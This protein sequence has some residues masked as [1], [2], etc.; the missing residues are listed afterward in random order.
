M[1][2]LTDDL[3]TGII[4]IDSQH[5]QLFNLINTI[6]TLTPSQLSSKEET[7][8]I[9]KLLGDYV[10]KHFQD[11]EAIQRKHNYPKYDEHKGKH[12]EFIKNFETLRN[13]YRTNG[14]SVAFSL[15]L[16]KS[17]IEWVVK[18]IKFADKEFAKYLKTN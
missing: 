6:T 2:S 18:H 13:E 15:M 5:Q 7:E 3:K 10:I 9:L 11:E 16:N 8:K 17:I 4:A 14:P 12:K 1:Y